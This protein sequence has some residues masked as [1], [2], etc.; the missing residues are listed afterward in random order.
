MK[1]YRET[2]AREYSKK[3]KILEETKLKYEKLIQK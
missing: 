3:F 2:Q 1:N